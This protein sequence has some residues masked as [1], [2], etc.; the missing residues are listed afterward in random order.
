MIMRL[1][2]LSGSIG[3]RTFEPRLKLAKDSLHSGTAMVALHRHALARVGV[4]P[5][6]RPVT[7]P[8]RLYWQILFGTPGKPFTLTGG[9][10]RHAVAGSVGPLRPAVSCWEPAGS[11][12]AHHD[13]VEEPF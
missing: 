11:F 13:R 10:G 8:C 2:D 7:D 1:V 9:L 3:A 6:V 4:A 12:P 5:P